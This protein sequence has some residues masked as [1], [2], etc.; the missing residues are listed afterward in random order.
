MSRLLFDDSHGENLDLE[1]GSGSSLFKLAKA[2]R[3]AGH[4][5][6]TI[7]REQDFCAATLQGADILV[8]AFPP[9]AS[10]TAT[11]GPSSYSWR[12]AAASY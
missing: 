5:V 4:T 2:L 1:E 12:T 10:P 3:G 6:N 9:S 11:W 8:I 7:H